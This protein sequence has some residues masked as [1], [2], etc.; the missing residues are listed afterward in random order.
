RHEGH[1]GAAAHGRGY[2]HGP[3][4][5]AVGATVTVVTGRL[6]RGTT[7]RRGSLAAPPW[8]AEPPPPTPPPE[9]APP[10]EPAPRTQASSSATS[11]TSAEG[12]NVPATVGAIRSPPSTRPSSRN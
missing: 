11:S 3:A 8:E 2:G 12:R 10:P 4:S 7:T 1:A 5:G 9:G 6:G